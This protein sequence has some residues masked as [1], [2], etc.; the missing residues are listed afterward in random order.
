MV[1]CQ[2]RANLLH[3]KTAVLHSCCMHWGVGVAQQYQNQLQAS[4]K[5]HG[6]S[7]HALDHSWPHHVLP[8]E[9]RLAMCRWSHN[10]QDMLPNHRLTACTELKQAA[11]KSLPCLQR[12]SDIEPTAN[13]SGGRQCAA[14][15]HAGNP[16]KWSLQDGKKVQCMETV[17]Q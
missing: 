16:L 14:H 17:G 2:D 10:Q 5:L 4:V 3:L 7:P 15:Y 8:A 13:C 11:T 9:T 1:T 6:L 12:V